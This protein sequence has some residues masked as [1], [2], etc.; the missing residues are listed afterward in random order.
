MTDDKGG[1]FLLYTDGG[2][3]NSGT[4]A[5]DDPPGEAGIGV[6]LT[7]VNENSGKEVT[8]KRFGKP[9]GPA[10]NAVAEYRAL[11]EGLR[12]A[13]DN[14]ARYV[15]AYMDSEF[16]VEQINNKKTP[17]QQDLVPLYEDAQKLIARFAPG[18]GFR[19][20]W[21]PRGRNKEADQ[22]AQQART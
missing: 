20:S 14:G 1:Y 16:V 12:S 2:M 19:L 17:K 10:T 22:L 13:L 3:D 5:K 15:R 11:V 7:K 18:N 8:L 4:R 6:V 9:I 21:I